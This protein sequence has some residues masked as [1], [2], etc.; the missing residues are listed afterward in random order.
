[1]SFSSLQA[2]F[3][4]S[5]LRAMSRYRIVDFG[6]TLVQGTLYQRSSVKLTD[7]KT[8]ASFEGTAE[9]ISKPMATLLATAEAYERLCQTGFLKNQRLVSGLPFGTGV[10]FF[11]RH[12]ELRAWGEYFE[13]ARYLTKDSGAEAP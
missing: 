8:G 9:N 1:M 7:L 13:R 3:K 2:H 11:R 5:L 6:H 10:G 12:A 4:L